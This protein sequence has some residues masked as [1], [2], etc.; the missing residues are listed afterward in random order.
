MHKKSQ[1]V[2]C[3]RVLV[4][5]VWHSTKDIKKANEEFSTPS[6]CNYGYTRLFFLPLLIFVY[7][8]IHGSWRLVGH[9]SCR[10]FV[11]E[12]EKRKETLQQ[13]V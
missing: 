4:D 10:V 1:M 9:R 6:M 5:I 7:S 13:H 11:R 12:K 3:I 8:D 2:L